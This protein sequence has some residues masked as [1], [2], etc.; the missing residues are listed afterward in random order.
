MKVDADGML[1]QR[2]DFRPAYGRA[3]KGTLS[4]DGSTFESIFEAA[5]DVFNETNAY[6]VKADE[7]QL[8]FITGR[9]D[10]ILAV[11]MA[12]EKAY[13]SFN[14][15]VQVTNKVIEAYKEIMRMQL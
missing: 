2:I 10:D 15:T 11:M 13:T 8:D 5:L 12:Q 7:A 3:E 6:Q 14:F 1:A 4:S 9:S